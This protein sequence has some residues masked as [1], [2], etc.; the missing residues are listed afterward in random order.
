MW[1][2][3]KNIMRKVGRRLGIIR[4]LKDVKDHKQINVD[5]KE[6]Y[7][8]NLNKRI[9]S[10]HVAEWHDLE[11]R[12]T[13]GRL[14]QRQQ[15]TM[16]M[17]KVVSQK[18]AGLMLNEGVKISLAEENKQ[19]QWEMINDVIESNKFKREIQRYVEYSLAMGGVAIEVYLDGDTP[20]LA[21]ATADAFYPI[22]T[23][24]E[25]IDEAVIVNQF[26]KDSKVY[27]LLKWHEWEEET[28]VVKNELYESSEYDEVGDR[29]ALSK[30]FPDMAEETHF[31]IDHP[32]FVYIKPNIANNKHI[33]SPLGLSIFDNAHDTLEILDVMYDFWYN[34]FR[35]GKRRVAVPQSLVKTHQGIDGQIFQYLDDSEELF[36]A[37]NDGEMD[38]FQIKDLT[39]DIR[40]DQ[41]IESIQSLLDILSVQTGLSAGTFT[42]T[43]KG[44]KTATQVVSENSETYRTRKS[45]LSIVEDALRD[46][47]VMIYDVATLDSGEGI[48]PL[49]R[50]DISIDFN[51]GIFQDNESKLKFYTDAVNA[52]LAPKVEAIMTIF[53]KSKEEAEEWLER[54]Q[55]EQAQS[56]SAVDEAIA[57][58]LITG[59][60]E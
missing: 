57:E 10:G 3:L 44:L 39:V 55:R 30:L 48:E 13:A 40:S 25:N 8:I 7:R 17:A 23:D 53:G 50:E 5:E 43:P 6:Y 19:A 14:I 12:G 24:T 42:F 46:L 26:T 52:G 27:R 36:V 31:Q 11:Y 51:D 45:H 29:V 34:E 35:L 28:Y 4:Y 47:I 49:K 37:L 59:G 22:S 41:V 38:E 15:K 54:I 58:L 60:R 9:Y 20:K 33:T 56:N 32:L 2:Q 18:L 21:Y 16:G 1:S